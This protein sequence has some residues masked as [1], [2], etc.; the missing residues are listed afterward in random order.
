[1]QERE[2]KDNRILSLTLEFSVDILKYCEELSSKKKFV[3]SD[4]L[5]RSGTSIGA[6]IWEAQ[7][8]ESKY[9]F[10]HKFKIAAKE[11]EET[12]YWL[13]LCKRVFREAIIDRLIEKLSEINRIVTSIIATSKRRVK[14]RK[15]G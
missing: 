8:A 12:Q 6:N 9:D 14:R 15:V 3:L 7:N 13:I 4:Q 5:C 11:V 10:I 2:I 1:M